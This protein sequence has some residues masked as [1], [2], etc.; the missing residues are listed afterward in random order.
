MVVYFE[1]KVKDSLR[2]S[3]FWSTLFDLVLPIWPS[4]VTL[5][6]H[7]TYPLGDVWPCKSLSKSLDQA[8]KERKEG[9]DFV[10]FHKLTQWL[11][12]SLVDAI[13][14]ETGWKV[15]KGLGQTGLPEVST[16][17]SFAFLFAGLIICAFLPCS[18][19][20]EGSLLTLEL[21]SSSLNR[22]EAM[23]TRTA[24]T[25][26]PSLSLPIPQSLSGGL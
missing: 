7:P 1:P 11:C 4:R 21:S 2:L 15:D 18:T 26:L 24:R 17:Q 25:N 14:S 3:D 12:Y 5:P 20:M 23:L 8:G 16:K 13:E 6:S 19:V 9:D 22:S 10:P